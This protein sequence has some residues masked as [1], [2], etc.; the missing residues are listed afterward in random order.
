MTGRSLLVVGVDGSPGALEALTWTIDHARSVGAEVHAV[1][2]CEPDRLPDYDSRWGDDHLPEVRRN[3]AKALLHEQVSRAVSEQDEQLVVWRHTTAGDPPTVLMEASRDATALVVGARGLGRLQGLLLG[4]VS[5][6]VAQRADVP[7]VVVRGRTDRRDGPVVVGVDGSA[8]SLS[9]LRWAADFARRHSA[10][11][12]VVHAWSL[13]FTMHPGALLLEAGRVRAETL[14]D[15]RSTVTRETTGLAEA[16]ADQD[17]VVAT[18]PEA[19]V[20]DGSPSSVLLQ[21]SQRARLVV[22]GSR[23][24]NAV[25]GQLLGSTSLSCVTNA[26]CSVAVIR[27]GVP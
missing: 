24:R 2:A 3:E 9:A 27:P 20:V 14:A 18:E 26:A 22:V 25:A 5:M 19:D 10:P 1:L 8:Q 6:H 21:E 4:S 12:R 7:V 15:L 16:P 17:V 11:L 23:G 13:P